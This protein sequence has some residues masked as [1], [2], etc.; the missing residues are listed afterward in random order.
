MLDIRIVEYDPKY[1]SSVAEMWNCSSE[2]WGGK[3]FKETEGSVLSHEAASGY[4]N[5]YLALDNNK[6]VGYCKL[7]LYSGDENTLFID[8]VSV[9]PVFHGQGIGKMLILK[10]VERTA[11]LG[12]PRLDLFT[13]TGNS[14]AIPM[15]KKCGFFWEKMDTYPCHLMNFIPSVLNCELIHEHLENFDWY[16][17]SIRLINMEIDGD[18][19]NGFEYYQYKWQKDGK[20]YMMEFEKNGRG[21]RKVDFPN[22]TI[23]VEIVDAKPVFGKKYQV[24]YKIVN[25]TDKPISLEIEGKDDQ[26]ICFDFN[27]KLTVTD[28]KTVIANYKINQLTTDINEWKTRPAVQT[29]ITVNGKRILFKIGLQVKPPLSLNLSSKNSI[30]YENKYNK[31][32]LNIENNFQE[33]CEFKVDIQENEKLILNKKEFTFMM[34]AF[35]KNSIELDFK[36]KEALVYNPVLKIRAIT[37]SKEEIYFQ[38]QLYLI[39]PTMTGVFYGKTDSNYILGSGTNKVSISAKS[40]IGSYTDCSNGSGFDFE[41]PRIGKPYSSEFEH[42]KPYKSE[43]VE[44]IRAIEMKLFYRSQDFEG[45]E[46]ARIF[47]LYPQGILECYTEILSLGTYSGEIWF[48][49]SFT[50]WYLN[51]TWNYEDKIMEFEDEHLQQQLSN[52]KADNV[53]ENWLFN[54]GSSFKTGICWPRS[55]KP[56]FNENNLCLEFNLSELYQSGNYTTQ[57]IIFSVNCFANAHQFREFALGQPLDYANPVKSLELE[58]NNGNPFLENDLTFS[59]TEHKNYDLCGKFIFETEYDNFHLQTEIT[60]NDKKRKIEYLIILNPKTILNILHCKAEFKSYQIERAKIFFNKSLGQVTITESV[61][62]DYSSMTVNNGFLS[63]KSSAEFASSIFS[64]SYKG[65]EW[66][67]TNYPQKG[68]KAWWNPWFGGLFFISDQMEF[69]DLL[70]EKTILKAVEKKDNHGNLWQGLE[71]S[72]KINHFTSLKGLSIKQYYLML[73]H[74]PVLLHFISLEQ[75]TGKSGNFNF[76]EWFCLK[77]D[78]EN[79]ESGFIVRNR[80]GAL[81]KLK[82]GTEYYNYSNDQKSPIAAYISDQSE[83]LQICS[84]LA[85]INFKNVGSVDSIGISVEYLTANFIENGTNKNMNPIFLVMTNQILEDE[86]LSDLYRIRFEE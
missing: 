80:S 63:I 27:K 73:P 58:I 25:K 52:W 31:M 20:E 85:P 39:L 78:K 1:A 54:S 51:I 75:N 60:Q 65:K 11:E 4:K 74:V 14:K 45:L 2:G 5:L 10:C 6:V 3:E 18:Y 46:F 38:K 40:N 30:F 77:T 59:L 33:S 42:I 7:S 29:E 68:T 16:E 9:D 24:E 8:K 67:D 21:L 23:S 34:S 28:Q 84:P 50:F 47:K 62:N 17:D 81:T 32:Y 53:S 48:N 13:W 49:F 43:F 66:L 41:F 36:L 86:W 22:L 12:Y 82:I 64:L 35:E 70:N 76:N 37:A 83:M 44:N 57:P 69:G 15:Y 55:M 79:S 61:E 19:C 71:I 72:M 56:V 26:N